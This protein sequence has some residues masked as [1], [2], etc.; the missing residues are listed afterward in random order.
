[1]VLAPGV[2]MGDGVLTIPRGRQVP[3]PLRI[4]RRAPLDAPPRGAP[5]LTGL[6]FH[7]RIVAEPE[8]DVTIVEEAFSESPVPARAPLPPPGA[9]VSSTVELTVG[10][11][12]RVRY[13]H[14]QNWSGD[15]DHTFAQ[16]ATVEQDGQLLSLLAV[17]GSR[18]TH[19]SVETRL[20]GPGA[21]SDLYG[22]AFGDQRQRFEFRTLQD[23]LVPNTASDLLYKT[24]LA[25]QAA[26]IYTGLIRIAKDAQQTDAYQ[27]NR[28]LLLSPQAKADSIPML[29]ILADDVRCTHGA[30]V[31]PVDPDHTF[32][33]MSRGI[34]FP[35]A[36]RMLVEGFFDQV[37][38]RL[39]LEE[40]REW[41][42]QGLSR[43]LGKG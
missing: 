39:P 14:I 37:I 20:A 17:L 10:A 6:T 25:D 19:A 2:V 33:L 18:T 29:E 13:Y 27:A 9:P 15:R 36:E 30:T 1:M 12:A 42:H 11:G 24:A 31:G 23:H 34:P 38:E 43:K 5:C 22:I 28:N 4:V 32:Y 3:A 26:S 7:T 16:R 21:R 40:L 35:A 8:S 41:L